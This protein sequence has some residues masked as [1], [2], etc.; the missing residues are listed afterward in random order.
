MSANYGT[1]SMNQQVRAAL[2]SQ[3]KPAARSTKQESSIANIDSSSQSSMSTHA[4]AWDVKGQA[5][6]RNQAG[7]LDGQNTGKCVN[8]KYRVSK[9]E[10]ILYDCRECGNYLVSIKAISFILTVCLCRFAST[11]STTSWRR[12]TSRPRAPRRFQTSRFLT[13]ARATRICL[14][15]TRMP[16]KRM[17][18][19]PPTTNNRPSRLANWKESNASCAGARRH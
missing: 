1:R 12:I 16:T 18:K 17:A 19:R 6:G 4:K 10:R 9:Q 11:V 14:T 3:Q 8:C 7:K 13:T 15:K 2:S 5:P